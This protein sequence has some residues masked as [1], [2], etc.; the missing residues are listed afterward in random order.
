MKKLL[1]CIFFIIG[2]SSYCQQRSENPYVLDASWFY[3][4]IAE[5]SQHIT[6]LITGHPDGIL[7]GFSRKTFGAEAWQSRYNYP[8]L[9]VSFSYQDLK[10]TSLGENYALYGHMSFY[11]LQ[12][13]LML[14]VGQGIA[15]ASNPYHP[16][17]NFRNTAYGSRFLSATKL[18]LNYKKENI[19]D[20]FGVQAGLAVLHYS[21]A[22]I[23]SPNTSTNTIAFNLGIN[24]VPDHRNLPEYIP[25]TTPE[26]YR[27]PL[28]L[29]F[30]LRTGVNST[31]ITGSSA[32]PFLTFSAFADKTLNN[33]STLQAGTELFLSGAMQARIRYQA[34]A[35]PYGETTGEE[36]ARRVGVFAGHQLTFDKLSVITQL[37]FYAWYPYE[38]Y[39]GRIYKRLG[40]QYA[41]NEKWWA[42]ATVRSH[43]A[44][45]ESL[46]FSVG[47]RI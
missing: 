17:N 21:N 38:H 31:G 42:S 29:N 5:H 23:K 8:D 37:G 45:A 25:R 34:E 10:N 46:E 1:C 41:I 2:S 16:D 28:H 40:L 44:N 13:N 47:Y 39:V 24:Y 30:A 12:R 18:L 11:F 35:F 3:G 32:H 4:S 9:G 15:Y 27:E 20:G 36:D 7:L 6:H 22:D 19:I 43:W 14:Q 33:K 26:D